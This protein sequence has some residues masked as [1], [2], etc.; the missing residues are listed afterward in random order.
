MRRF[1]CSALIA[2]APFALFAQKAGGSGAGSTS[3]RVEGPLRTPSG[4]PMAGMGGGWGS[5]Y[6]RS[7]DFQ[8]NRRDVSRE[9][10]IRVSGANPTG[11]GQVMNHIRVIH[12]PKR[13]RLTVHPDDRYWEKRDLWSE[14]QA[15]ARSGCIPVV[16]VDDMASLE[17]YSFWMAGWKAYGMMVPPKETVTFTL[18]HS[19]RGWFHLNL[20]NKWGQLEPG[21]LHTV[22]HRGTPQIAY[23]NPSDDPRYAYVV[24]DDPGW[25]S[26]LG[27]PYT[28]TIKRSWD[29]GK[30]AKEGLPT[31]AGIWAQHRPEKPSPKLAVAIWR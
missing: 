31:A 1:I 20:C 6:N 9:Q 22:M 24:V 21:M 13:P 8:P 17:D 3:P 26:S 10:P 12:P 7:S 28:L 15:W 2:A 16:G 14:L 18:D 27:N 23:T 11:N 19:N 25:M 4:A 30:Y 5:D 29:P